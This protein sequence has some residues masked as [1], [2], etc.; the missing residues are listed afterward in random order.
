MPG[1]RSI[2]DLIE[3]STLGTPDAVAMQERTPPEVARRL[4]ARANGAPCCDLHG[5]HCEAPS[6]LCCWR[7]WEAA[8]VGLFPHADGTPCVLEADNDGC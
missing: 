5:T 7:C 3:A 4:V 6:E 1:D 8:H 2:E